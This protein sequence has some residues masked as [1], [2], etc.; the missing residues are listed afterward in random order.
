M[1]R[2][3]FELLGWDE[4]HVVWNESLASKSGKLVANWA[5]AVALVG[6][7]GKENDKKLSRIIWGFIPDCSMYTTPGTSTC[8][9]D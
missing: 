9:D 8:G 3:S 1:I 7:G 5:Y 6:V 2:K 4:S